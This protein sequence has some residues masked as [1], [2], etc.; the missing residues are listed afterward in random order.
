MTRASA[1]RIIEWVAA[2]QGP[3]LALVV[4]VLAFGE[5][6]A[7]VD[8]VVP[9]EVGMV[10]A[11]AAAERSGVPLWLLI[12]VGTCGAIVGDQVS[13]Q[14]GRNF[15]AGLADRWAWSRRHVCPKIDS[16]REHFARWG[17]ATVFVSR[18]VGAMRAVVPFVAGTSDMPAPR[19][20][21]W[22]AIGAATWVSTVI[23]LGYVFGR[24]ISDFIDRFSLWI[25]IAAVVAIASW[26]ALRKARSHQRRSRATR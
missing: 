19:F 24:T 18:W 25:S 3:T 13:Y 11:G 9:G 14:L 12:V 17:P 23:T 20:V 8:V 7:A 15:G 22:N 26:W 10:V 6:A 5:S 4:F 2:L 21:V 16:A 1:N